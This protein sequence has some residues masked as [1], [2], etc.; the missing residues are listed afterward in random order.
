MDSPFHAARRGGPGHGHSNDHGQAI[1]HIL[2]LAER[3]MRLVRRNA[4]LD[5]KT[6]L[7]SSPQRIGRLGAFVLEPQRPGCHQPLSC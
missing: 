1:R 3:D 5:L 6:Q 2:P 7:P 4:T